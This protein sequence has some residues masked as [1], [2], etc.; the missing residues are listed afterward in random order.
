MISAGDN[1]FNR[2]VGIPALKFPRQYKFVLVKSD[3][4]KGKASGSGLYYEQRKEV[5]VGL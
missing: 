3:C 1:S 5:G 4:R 2:E